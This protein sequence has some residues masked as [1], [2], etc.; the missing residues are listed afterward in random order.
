MSTKNKEVK[1]ITDIDLDTGTNLVTENYQLEILGLKDLVDLRKFSRS[2]LKVDKLLKSIF[3]GKEDR[4]SKNTGFNKNKSD[5]TNLEDSETI[6]TSM[7]VAKTME[8]AEEALD[9]AGGKE[10]AFNKNTAFNKNFGTGQNEVLEGNKL[11][12]ILGI[13]YGGILNNTNAKVAGKGYYDTANK[14]IYKCTTNTTINYADSAY[15]EEISNNDLLGKLQNL[16]IITAASYG[17][18]QS[19]FNGTVKKLGIFTYQ[20]TSNLPLGLNEVIHQAPEGYIILCA[21]VNWKDNIKSNEFIGFDYERNNS[22]ITVAYNATKSS[23]SYTITLLCAK[24]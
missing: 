20:S 1:E 11:A 12:E 18:Q 14:K 23:M 15:F 4:F 3:T 7:A 17:T 24:I 5:A 2:F 8:K 19:S 13:E 16:S 6:A 21:W 10:P 22:F 9:S